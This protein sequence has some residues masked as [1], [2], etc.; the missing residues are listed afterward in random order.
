MTE[1]EL[2]WH[3]GK[4]MNVNDPN[5]G[6]CDECGQPRDKNYLEC[7]TCGNVMKDTTNQCDNCNMM[8]KGNPPPLIPNAPIQGVPTLVSGYTK[9]DDDK[10][11]RY[12][13]Q[14][15]QEVRDLL[16]K[17]NH[18]YG[19]SFLRPLRV[20]A[21]A[22]PLEQ[23]RVRMD[24]KLSR[25]MNLKGKGALVEEDTYMDMAGYSILYLV[26]ER[27]IRE[28]LEKMEEAERK[29]AGEE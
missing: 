4:C 21:N 26:A 11:R 3:C 20:F 29:D 10:V 23:I 5:F 24:D 12:I 27:I 7:E 2:V 15:C 16:L 25:I 8:W 19:S 6:I 17:K 13:I 1:E 22:D 18:D 14:M 28:E 9:V